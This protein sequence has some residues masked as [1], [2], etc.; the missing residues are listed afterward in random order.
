MFNCFINRKKLN[1]PHRNDKLKLIG[2][3][4]DAFPLAS[5]KIHHLIQLER[6]HSI[7][8][9]RPARNSVQVGSTSWSGTTAESVSAANR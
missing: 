4:L 1:L 6:I 3:L 9:S 8:G 7:M 5:S 2:H